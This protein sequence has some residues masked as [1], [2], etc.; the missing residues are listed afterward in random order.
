MTSR[1]AVVIGGA[2][3]VGSALARKLKSDG[4]PTLTIG[5][6]DSLPTQAGDIFF[7]AGVTADFR[8]RPYDTLEAHV[9]LVSDVLRR[10]DFVSL[11][12]LSSTRVYQEAAAGKEDVTLMVNPN[13]PSHLYNLSKLTGE[14][15]CLCDPRA[16]VRVVRL[17]NVFGKGGSSENFLDAVVGEALRN[18][19][20]HIRSSAEAAKDYIAVDDVV[21]ALVRVPE[22]ATSRLMNLASGAPTTNARIG[23]LLIELLGAKVSYGTDVGM[24]FPVIDIDRMRAELGVIPRPFESAFRRWLES[25]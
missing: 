24:A 17:S 25:V 2:G 7:C 16:M 18:G 23:E 21:D 9:A 13:D 11:T 10:V 8:H 12:Y 22:N 3:F 14:A 6:G 19:H 15:A 20:V 1:P 5:R 4:L